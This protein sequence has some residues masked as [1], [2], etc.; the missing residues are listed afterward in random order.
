MKQRTRVPSFSR[1]TMPA[2]ARTPTCLETFCCVAPS[3][4]V[5]LVDGH[6][7][8]A[9]RVED[10]DAHRLAEHAEALGDELDE[11]AGKRVGDRGR[12]R[13]HVYN[14]TTEQL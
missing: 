8:V 6:R 4:S 12:D 7:P 13:V 2:C 10:A 3:A 1:P 14:C 11:R 5:Q 9:Q